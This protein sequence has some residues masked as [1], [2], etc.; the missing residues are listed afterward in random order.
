MAERL[1]DE[2]GEFLL[3]FYGSEYALGFRGERDFIERG[4]NF[5]YNFSATSGKLHWFH[6]GMAYVLTSQEKLFNALKTCF[7]NEIIKFK[8]VPTLSEEKDEENGGK[9]FVWNEELLEQRAAEMANKF[10]ETKV[11]KEDFMLNIER[12]YCS[13][14][15]LSQQTKN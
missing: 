7:Y 1:L 8:E 14:Y 13:E 5:A 12:Q 2:N 15:M 6:D 11:K 10:L 3:S 9:L 4:Y